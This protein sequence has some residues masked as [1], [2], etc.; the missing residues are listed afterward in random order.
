MQEQIQAIKQLLETNNWVVSTIEAIL[1]DSIGEKASW[2]NSS[3]IQE[4]QDGTSW[5]EIHPHTV[6]SMLKKLWRSRI[7][8]NTARANAELVELDQFLTEAALNALAKTRL[9]SLVEARNGELESLKADKV[10]SSANCD[11]IVKQLEAELD[12]RNA[13]IKER[14]RTIY[15][16]DT[17]VDSL[18][19]DIKERDLKIENLEANRSNF[20]ALESMLETRNKDVED[21]KLAIAD[22]ECQARKLVSG[23]STSHLRLLEKI[24]ERDREIEALQINKTQFLELESLLE[25][26]NAE[27]GN[28]KL[29]LSEVLNAPPCYM[30]TSS[31]QLIDLMYMCGG[32]QGA[33]ATQPNITASDICKAF[34]SDVLNARNQF[35]RDRANEGLRFCLAN[36]NSIQADIDS[37]K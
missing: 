10:V 4:L 20:L 27:I 35:Q 30:V 25:A 9:E 7:H 12:I 11:R 19:I 22:T 13:E 16:L 18:R 15:V 1:I 34:A 26:R 37:G 8:L 36:K 2:E 6:I 21:L 29:A 32:K 24:L 5:V 31:G 17:E 23:E 28:L 33:I 3:Q 14:D